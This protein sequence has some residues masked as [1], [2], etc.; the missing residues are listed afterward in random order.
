MLCRNNYTQ[1]YIDECR[2]K[3]ESQIS[4]YKNLVKAAA[5]KKATKLSLAIKSF[6]TVFFN[7]MVLVLENYF[8]HRSRTIE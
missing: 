5:D 7:N 3:V 8:V 6:E 4:A 2:K 1:K